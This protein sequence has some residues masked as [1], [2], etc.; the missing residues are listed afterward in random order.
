MWTCDVLDAVTELRR[1]AGWHPARPT[2]QTLSSCVSPMRDWVQSRREGP[3]MTMWWITPAGVAARVAGPA[4]VAVRGRD[5]NH[6]RFK[7]FTRKDG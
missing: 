7:D 2:P 5:L 3:R 6:P 1:L 4:I